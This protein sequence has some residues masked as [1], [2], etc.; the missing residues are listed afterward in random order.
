MN[1]TYDMDK[2]R[3]ISED[4][5][6]CSNVLIESTEDMTR[7]PYQSPDSSSTDEAQVTTSSQIELNVCIDGLESVSCL[8][9]P[10]VNDVFRKSST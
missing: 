8:L 10:A 2:S 4:G 9:A 3:Q 1:T 5:F 6:R 7:R